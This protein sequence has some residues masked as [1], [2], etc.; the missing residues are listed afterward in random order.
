MDLEFN[1]V[2]H[3][4]PDCGLQTGARTPLDRHAL[5]HV[6]LPQVGGSLQLIH[7]LPLHSPLLQDG[8]DL[9]RLR[10]DQ[11]GEAVVLVAELDLPVLALDRLV[12]ERDRHLV[13]RFV[14]AGIHAIGLIRHE[15]ALSVREEVLGAVRHG[16]VALHVRRPHQS[17]E[18]LLN[19]LGLED[20]TE[21]VD[22]AVTAALNTREE[23]LV[24]L[25]DLVQVVPQP[26]VAHL[27]EPPE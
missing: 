5:V 11:F 8:W 9:Q 18:F 6:V 17:L 13:T 4:C 15:H 14:I 25:Y 20:E 19:E 26:L 24:D 21:S 10:Q 2:Q 22:V 12:H 7:L 16:L 23:I 3:G 27:L 1:V